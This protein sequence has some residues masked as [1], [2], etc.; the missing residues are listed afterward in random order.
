MSRR[1]LQRSVR[2]VGTRVFFEGDRRNFFKPLNGCQRELMADCL[3]TAYDRL[4]G[5]GADYSQSLTRELLREVWLPVIQAHAND[6][7]LDDSDADDE[8]TVSGGDQQQFANG[9]IRTLYKC[10]W[11]ETYGDRAGLVTAYKFSRAGKLFAEA[12]WSLDRLRARSRQRNVRSC[13]NALE[14]TRRNVDAYD[15]VDAYD[16]AEKVISDLSEGVEYFQELVRRL[17]SEASQTPWDEFMEF[18][19][20]FEKDF[21][22]QLTVDSVERHRQAI[23]ES[24]ARL[25]SIEDDKYRMLEAQLQDIASW[26]ATERSGDSTYYWLLDRIEEMV[27]AACTT[28]HPELIRAMNT[29]MRRAANIVQQALMLRSGQTRQ[30]YIKA[31]ALLAERS[32]E[33]QTPLLE[34]LGRAIAGAEVRLLDPALFKLR[35]MAQRRKALTLTVQPKV[36]RDSRLAAAILRA[37][38]GAFALSNDDVLSDL[39]HELRLR[40]RPVRLSSLPV[41]SATDILHIMQ[42]V[43]AVRGSRDETLKATKLPTRLWNNYFSGSDYQIEMSHEPDKRTL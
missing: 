38:A 25:R 4:H 12:L 14:A 20:K 33:E 39:R 42:A 35:S 43:E 18:L 9:V 11:L 32:G 40:G 5:P 13:R 24:V 37:E 41:K 34:K 36:T 30:S 23:R 15:L 8:W 19:D 10:G 27:E 1:T 21:K 17:M 28:K 26:A 29:Y 16:Y 22:K 7:A 3:R 2:K 6:A 31:I